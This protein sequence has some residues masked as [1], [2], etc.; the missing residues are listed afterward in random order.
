MRPSGSAADRI[1]S[2]GNREIYRRI[3]E[4]DPGH[5]RGGFAP[6]TLISLDLSGFGENGAYVERIEEIRDPPA[7]WPVA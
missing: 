3:L 7:K 1:G 4:T 2:S 6:L 5:P